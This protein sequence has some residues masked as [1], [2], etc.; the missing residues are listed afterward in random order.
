M[1]FLRTASTRRLLAV[2]AG[3]V[4]VIVAGS[5]I[6]IA[7]TRGGP[8]P[9][10]KPLASA[11]HGALSAPTVSGFSAQVSFTNALIDASNIQGSD[12][13]LNA[14]GGR[15]WLS[16][17]H[18]LRLELRGDNGDA[19][20]VLTDKTF[21]AYDPTSNTFYEGWLPA[22]RSASKSSG[23]H[24]GIP[25]VAQ[26]QSAI[27]QLAGHVTVSSAIPGDI[28]GRPTYTVRLTPKDRGGL[29]DGV[30]LAWDAV[31]G[32]PLSFAVYARGTSKPVL[33]LTASDVSY[34]RVP[35]GVFHLTPPAGAHV[36]KVTL[37]TGTAETAPS[38]R[39]RTH[40]AE[41]SGVNAVASHL[42]F[43][44]DAP[45]TL[46]GLSRTSV[47][48]LG[49][50]KQA[51]AVVSYGQGLGAIYVIERPASAGKLP[52]MTQPSGDQPG[53]SLPSVTLRGHVSAVELPTALGTVLRFARG[54]V[55]YVVGGSVS[56]AQAESAARSL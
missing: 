13:L 45:A 56:Q 32:V 41:I 19:E 46:A 36:D 42:S 54:G 23:K 20:V 4:V 29:F 53:L 31:R 6:A 1:R 25:S 14:S 26:I 40:R 43:R 37:P 34:G 35:A 21:S 3:L 50:G 49:R 47:T 22:D 38:A 11:I 44:L 48:L 9:P 28:A 5:A 15:L 24:E 33:Q 7:A 51:G 27:T 18:G 2:L 39:P 8:V 52:N 16:P 12:P 17:G 55:G 10:K 30:S